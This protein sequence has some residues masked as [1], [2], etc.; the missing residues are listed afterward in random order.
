[1]RVGA[2]M[3]DAKEYWGGEIGGKCHNFMT[4]AL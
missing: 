1:M 3:R 2:Q 4:F